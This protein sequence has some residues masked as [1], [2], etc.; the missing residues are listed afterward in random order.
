[1]LLDATLSFLHFTF[2]L[3]MTA[4]IGAEVFILRLPM[5]APVMRLL[6]RV[7]AFYGAAAMG[8]IGA[9]I[10]RVFFGLR[11]E[12]YYLASHAFWTK[13]AIILLVGLVSIAPTLTF[14]R[15]SRALKADA[16][17]LPDEKSVRAARAMAGIE[18]H[19]LALAVLF[20]VW[21]ARGAV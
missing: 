14:M 11:D 3:I 17:F 5:S 18:A 1:M 16:N 21:M 9:G 19:L 15:W 2:L 4:A 12:S 13:M 10:A 20:A 7:D 6:S 8:L